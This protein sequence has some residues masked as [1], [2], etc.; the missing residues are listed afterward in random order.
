VSAEDGL[1][2][3]CPNTLY[4]GAGRGEPA[5]EIRHEDDA[6]SPYRMK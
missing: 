2:I 6:N 5:D 3:N 4:M 1:V